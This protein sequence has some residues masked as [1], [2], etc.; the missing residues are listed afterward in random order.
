MGEAP[1]SPGT[2]EERLLAGTPDEL[3]GMTAALE[4][5]ARRLVA[6]IAAAAAPDT[7]GA[8]PPRSSRLAV[9]IPDPTQHVP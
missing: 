7:A 1:Y 2:L 8:P 6:D 9:C 3:H 5:R 4:S